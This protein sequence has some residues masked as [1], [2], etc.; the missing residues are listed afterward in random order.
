MIFTSNF[1]EFLHTMY[2]YLLN[3]V[4]K[5]SMTF[6]KNLEYYTIKLR[7]PF[8]CGHAVFLITSIAAINQATGYTS[9]HIWCLSQARINWEGCL[10]KDI[11]HKKW[12]MIK[13]RC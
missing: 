11:G 13:V 9:Q 10:R 5:I 3:S 1:Q 7:G 2:K 4:V 6:A 12:G 8:F